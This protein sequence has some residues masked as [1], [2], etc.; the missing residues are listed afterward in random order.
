MQT[1]SRPASENQHVL[2]SLPKIVV[3]AHPSPR[4]RV[5]QNC[6]N[7]ISQDSE[8]FSVLSSLKVSALIKIKVPGLIR[9]WGEKKERKKALGS[10]AEFLFVI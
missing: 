1:H 3:S 6:N 4:T 9:Q 5:R 7:L 10:P 2:G 8:N